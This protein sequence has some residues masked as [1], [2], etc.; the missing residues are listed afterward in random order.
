MTTHKPGCGGT[1]LTATLDGHSYDYC[2]RCAAFRYEDDSNE[3]FPTG[4]DRQANRAA[5]DG[6]ETR[7]PEA[8]PTHRVSYAGG[9]EELCESRAEAMRLARDVVGADAVAV[10]TEDGTYLYRTQEDAD[11]D[12]GRSTT[13]AAVVSRIEDEEARS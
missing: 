9:R 7:S 4:D 11:A 2:D 6:Q 10:R 13:A 1:I 8:A 3:S 12:E 5:W